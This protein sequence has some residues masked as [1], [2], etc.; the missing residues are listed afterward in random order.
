[1]MHARVLI[2]LLLLLPPVER[3]GAQVG[4]SGLAFLKL[5]V[6]GR[7]LAMGDAMSALAN[8]SAAT[9]YNPAG[10]VGLAG[11]Q[12]MFMHREWIQDTRVEFFGTTIP[13]GE[14]NA[15]GF[16]LNSTTVSN[17]D[18]RTRP[19][20]SEGT[21][22]ARN[23]GLGA[24]FA[25]VFSADLRMGFSGRYLYEKILVDES[26]GYAFDLGA[27]L[28]T[29]WE[30]ITVGAALANIGSMKGLREGSTTLPALL[31]IGPAYSQS[32][33][34]TDF[35][36]S[37]A[38]DLLYIFPEKKSYLNTGGEF[39]FSKNIAVRLGYQFGS[40][41]RGLAAGVGLAYGILIFD[42][43]YAHLSND[44]GNAHTFS[45]ALNL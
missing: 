8:G 33:E 6:S 13:M 10:I 29:P 26:Q 12:V 41:G 40:E 19:G 27:Q 14:S 35:G 7:G 16:A 34:G 20:P 37:I 5:G 1:M 2:L 28:R 45:L 38:S 9:Y 17:I 18:I 23:F 43:A 25:H 32:I 39:V 44:L 3:A 42:Y 30:N 15:L 4:N 24:T 22:T 36:F 21:F 31:R 11:T